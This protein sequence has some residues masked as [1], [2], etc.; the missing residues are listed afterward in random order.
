MK[1]DRTTVSHKLRRPSISILALITLS[2]ILMLFN[3]VQA[4]EVYSIQVQQDTLTGKITDSGTDAPLVGVT[5]QIMQTAEIT[6]VKGAKTQND[7]TYQLSLPEGS[8]T[9][10]V[11]I[12]GY[13][14]LMIDIEGRKV[15]DIAMDKLTSQEDNPLWGS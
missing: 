2:F 9:L 15:I 4:S 1:K 10:I 8:K 13:K 12:S 14:T 7:G 11:S 3:T 5:I 6:T